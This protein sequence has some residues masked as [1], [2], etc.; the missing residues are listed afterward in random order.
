M[1]GILGDQHLR[2]HGFGGNAALDDSRWCRG[3]N[4]RDL[5]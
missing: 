4:D 3:L 2:D 5:A 1:I